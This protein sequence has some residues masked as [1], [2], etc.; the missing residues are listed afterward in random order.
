MSIEGV[1]ENMLVGYGLVVGLPGMGD[2]AGSP[3]TTRLLGSMMQNMGF[4]DGAAQGQRGWSMA[5]V[6]V[7]A[8]LPAFAKP[9][10]RI[11]VDVS[12]VGDATEVRGGTL[13]PT[14]L[15]AADR[16][17]YG[18]GRGNG[19]RLSGYTAQGGEPPA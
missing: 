6:M 8:N 2:S 1:R 12:P 9:G 14:A 16:Q 19:G 4:G 17:V 13:L 15:E 11:D 7:T 3:I 18:G 5:A 10:N